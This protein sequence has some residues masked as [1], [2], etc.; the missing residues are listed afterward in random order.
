MDTRLQALAGSQNGTFCATE[1]LAAG[2]SAV[3]L[4][5]A[6]RAGD[7]IRVRRQAYVSAQVWQGADDAERYRLTCLAVARTRPGD[8]LSHHAAIAVHGLPLWGYDAGRVDFAASV[9]QGVRRGR[10]WLH[11][12]E[13]VETAEVGGLRVVS[14][15]RAIVR[16]ALTMGRDCAVVAGDAGLHR[17][18]VTAEELRAEVA[19][20]TPHQGRGRALAAVLRMDGRAESVG[21]S[22]TRLV[23]DALGL[24]HESQVVLRDAAGRFVARVDLLVEGV[25]VEFDGKV[26]YGRSRDQEDVATDAG[27]TLWLEKRREDGIRRLG[28]PVERVV[29]E[30]LARPGLIGARIR[31]ARALVR[32]PQGG[33]RSTA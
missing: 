11:P 5:R 29:W 10:I 19:R 27:E 28:H 22:R 13:R 30:D 15:A 24:A 6:V 23:V 2:V 16:A 4:H 33:A 1:A 26:K 21:E 32:P 12:G 18:L 9:R 17:G 7:L 3:E 20:V 8:A 31:A 14:P 25:V